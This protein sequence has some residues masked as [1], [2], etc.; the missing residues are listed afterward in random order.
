MNA[1][2]IELSEDMEF[3]CVAE[4]SKTKLYLSLVRSP[5]ERL[6]AAEEKRRR[7]YRRKLIRQAVLIGAEFLKI[8]IAAVATCVMYHLLS[9]HLLE[10]RGYEAVGSEIIFAGMFYVAV[11]YLTDAVI[12]GG[13]E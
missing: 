12:G 3:Q 13:H 8:G 5:G 1:C 11:W 7:R 6:R 10:Q 2:R 4:D 9:L